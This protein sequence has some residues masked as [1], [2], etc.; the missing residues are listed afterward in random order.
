MKLKYLEIFL[1]F[2]RGNIVII[3]KTFHTSVYDN[4]ETIFFLT[5]NRVEAE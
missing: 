3:T 1:F 5:D 2:D 4:S